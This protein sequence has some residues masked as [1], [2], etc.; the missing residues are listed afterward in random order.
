MQTHDYQILTFLV[1]LSGTVFLY[2]VT[3]YYLKRSRNPKQEAP[4]HLPSVAV[5]IAMRNEEDY[6]HHCLKSL[7]RQTYPKDRHQIIVIDD[8]STDSSPEIVREYINRNSNFK[9]LAIQEQ[10]HGLKGKMNALEQALSETDQQIILITDA[11][12]IVPRGWINT[13][14]SY[15]K[16]DVGLVGGLTML[17]PGFGRESPKKTFSFFNKIQALDWLFLQFVSTYA[18]Q[19]GKPITVLGNNF[20]F[21]KEAYDLVGGFKEIG[22]SV[23]EDYVLMDAIAR[24][25]S[26]KIIH[27]IDPDNTI[28][29]FP[30]NTLKEFYSQ[31]KRWM[32]G[33]KKSGFWTYYLLLLTTIVHFLL[34]CSLFIPGFNI[35]KF[36]LW[37]GILSTDY[38]LLS[39]A[40]N[41]TNTNSLKKYF[42]F[43]EVFYFVYS[44]LF[45][46]LALFP[47]RVI[48]KGRYYK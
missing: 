43:F 15:F 37:L 46:F 21:R 30:V 27:T 36:L 32:I 5:L 19:V 39:S 2:I 42:V 33:G 12:C 45:A 10:R 31:R 29:S 9:M 4:K 35:L 25:G 17:Y 18:S 13:F 1:L 24:Q 20:G 14:V 34:I 6:I 26:W 11:D 41:H 40:L 23:T 16:R 3:A 22:F 38:V 28:F 7:E 8:K 47:S 44:I 48:W